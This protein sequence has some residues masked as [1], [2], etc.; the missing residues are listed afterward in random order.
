[1]H[2]FR[3]F[4]IFPPKNLEKYGR[5]KYACAVLYFKFF[6]LAVY[7]IVNNKIYFSCVVSALLDIV[8]IVIITGQLKWY[9]RSH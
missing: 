9:I 8:Y 2:S 3:K 7:K 4:S 5:S 6:H 1:M